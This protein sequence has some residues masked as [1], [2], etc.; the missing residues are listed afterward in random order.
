MDRDFEWR[1][2]F[3]VFTIAVSSLTSSAPK[4]SKRLQRPADSALRAYPW[5]LIHDPL[6]GLLP[7]RARLGY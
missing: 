3:E 1:E 2:D 7:R 5:S 4:T 6:I